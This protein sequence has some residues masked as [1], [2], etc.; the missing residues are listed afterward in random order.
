MINTNMSKYRQEIASSFICLVLRCSV[1]ANKVERWLLFLGGFSISLRFFWD[2]GLLD[3]LRILQSIYWEMYSAFYCDVTLGRTF[4]INTCTSMDHANPKSDVRL[5]SI[6]IY[7]DI[8]KESI[9]LSTSGIPT[10]TLLLV[11]ERRAVQD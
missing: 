4:P 3:M 8:W 10:E 11:L 9:I 1:H 5:D 7:S 6:G 2:G